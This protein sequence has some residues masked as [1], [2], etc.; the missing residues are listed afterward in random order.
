MSEENISKVDTL[1]IVLS[2]IGIV[3]RTFLWTLVTILALVIA[4]KFSLPS[5]LCFLV[6]CLIGW[7]F[8]FFKL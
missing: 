5:G 3:V 6:A 2:I 4:F 8:L 7:Y 1:G